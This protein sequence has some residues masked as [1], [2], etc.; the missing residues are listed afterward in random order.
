MKITSPAFENNEQISQK[1][2]CDGEDINPPL[3]FED[4]PDEAASL[5]LIISD[6][7]APGKTFYHWVLFNIDPGTDHIDEDSVPGTALEGTND[8]G[9]IEYGGPC[10]PFGTHRY[11]FKLYALNDI[12]NL[13]EG[14]TAQ[15]VEQEME[16]RILENAEITGIYAR[17]DTV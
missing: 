17:T 2:T 13:E 4:I 11:I 3:R 7:D 10:P 15:E 14:A 16:R 6:P 5:A 9:N 8:F 1:Y 12:L